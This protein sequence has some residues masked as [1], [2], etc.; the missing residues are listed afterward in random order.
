MRIEVYSSGSD[1]NV[2]LINSNNTNILVDV[3]LSKKM[4]EDNMSSSNLDLSMI[5]GILI[6]HEHIDHIRGLMAIINKYD[7]PVYL[8]NGTFS[9]IIAMYRAKN[10]SK[11]VDKLKQ[12]Y[13]DDL[14]RII[15]REKDN[16][17]YEP[18]YI[19]D[20]LVQ[21]LPT[22]HDAKEPVGFVFTSELKRL[23][24]I[25]D[26]GYIHNSLF[27]LISNAE[28]YLLEANHDPDILLSSN[29][30]YA[31]KMRILSDY[32]H[33]S[34]LDSMLTLVNVIGPDTKL[35]LHAH[36]STEC[37]LSQIIELERQKVFKEYEVSEKNIRFVILKA[38]KKDV[39]EI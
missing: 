29:R 5:D 11:S 10:D 8:T 31:L 24:Y 33:L 39:F 2:T 12:K 30:P 32:G 22:F 34:N 9:A 35:V 21:P 27:E 37:N 20:I 18:F 28:G 6:T 16:F 1:G 36:V 14:I 23:V 7:I 19:K 38:Y 4:I 13:A 26:T 25:T 17:L 3:G 15:K